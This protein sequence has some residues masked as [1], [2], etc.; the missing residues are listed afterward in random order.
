MWSPPVETWCNEVMYVVPPPRNEVI[1]VADKIYHDEAGVY[2]TN[3][4]KSGHYS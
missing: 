1:Y 2:V 3:Q 4:L